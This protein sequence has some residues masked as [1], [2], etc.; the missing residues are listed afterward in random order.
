M[1]ERF[2]DS[3]R[4]VVVL[5]QEEARLLSHNYIGTEHLLLAML[6]TDAGGI[7]EQAL[8]SVG[9]TYDA[10]RVQVLEIVGGGSEAPS[11]HIPFTTRAK[12]VLEHSLREALEVGDDAIESEHILLG[13]IR[14]GTG[15]GTQV[16]VKLGGDLSQLRHRVIGLRGTAGSEPRRAVARGAMSAHAILASAPGVVPGPLALRCPFC[17]RAEDKAEHLVVAG[18]MILCD[19]CARDAV[20]QLDALPD[21]A[22]RRVRFRRREV[23]L[24]D[25]DA[26]MR[27]IERAFEAV[28][29]PAHLPPADAVWAVEGGAATEPMLR[30]LDEAAGHAPVTVND[31]TV[32]RVRFLD[33]DEAEV[34]LGIWIAGNPQPLLQ[35]A[36]AVR[37]QGTWKVSRATVEFYAAQASQFRRR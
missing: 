5:A 13:L 10:A 32:E 24:T 18:G 29:G 35:S 26:A 2:S 14:E 34:S 15:V 8:R 25:K 20:A 31:V 11:G 16:V 12:Q 21:D 28:I 6:R 19:Q 22:P 3:A 33:G 4:R 9:I 17:G 30:Q 27:A 7:A 1:F 23:G 36:H 37:E